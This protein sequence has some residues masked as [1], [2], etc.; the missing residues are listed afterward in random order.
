MK[1]IYIVHTD[2]FSPVEHVDKYYARNIDEIE[3]LIRHIFEETEREIISYDLNKETQEITVVYK[4]IIDEAE[5]ATYVF[6]E[7]K[8]IKKELS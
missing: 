8:S 5:T 3:V 1:P 6:T 2:S 4:D 7:F